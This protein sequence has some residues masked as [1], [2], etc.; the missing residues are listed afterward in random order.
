MK[1]EI[2]EKLVQDLW[3]IVKEY[4]HCK[5]EMIGE[6]SSLIKKESEKKVRGFVEWDISS[7][8]GKAGYEG[9]LGLRLEEAEEYLGGAER[10][11]NPES[12]EILKCPYC[13]NPI[14]ICEYIIP[15]EKRDSPDRVP[16]PK[17]FKDKLNNIV[18]DFE[19]KFDE[20]FNLKPDGVDIFVKGFFQWHIGNTMKTEILKILDELGDVRLGGFKVKDMP[21][22][23]KGRNAHIYE[24][25]QILDTKL[26]EIRER[27]EEEK[28]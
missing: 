2:E 22:V 12:D 7:E 9:L 1:K 20:N 15:K 24:V 27:Y 21:R 11:E 19:K 18:G 26:Q 13:K 17:E 25:L 5:P 8:K 6:L 23:P 10:S 3:R 4:N 28:N 16:A 14:C